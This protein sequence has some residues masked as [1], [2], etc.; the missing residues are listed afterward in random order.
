[1]VSHS[2]FTHSKSENPLIASLLATVTIQFLSATAYRWEIP[3][4]RNMKPFCVGEGE[5]Q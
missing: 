3:Y 1:M 2:K 5:K 4:F